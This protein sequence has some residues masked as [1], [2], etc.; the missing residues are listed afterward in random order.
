MHVPSME[1]APRPVIIRPVTQFGSQQGQIN[2]AVSGGQSV[3]LQVLPNATTGSTNILQ[4]I[5]RVL[6]NERAETSTNTSTHAS[7]VV[8]SCTPN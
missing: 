7:V 5:G 1:R 2:P 6:G 3:K 4:A 8:A